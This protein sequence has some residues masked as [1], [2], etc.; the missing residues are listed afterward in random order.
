MSRKGLGAAVPFSGRGA[1]SLGLSTL[2]LASADDKR[3]PRETG[4]V[5][6]WATSGEN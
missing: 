6:T 1:F 4:I 3:V 5:L 2:S